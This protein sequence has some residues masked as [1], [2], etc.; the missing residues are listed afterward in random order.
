M[1]HVDDSLVLQS[2]KLVAVATWI[3]WKI[4]KKNWLALNPFPLLVL[5]RF[6]CRESENK[7]RIHKVWYLF[8]P[9]DNNLI[10]WDPALLS[11]QEP[12]MLV[13]GDAY[14]GTRE[15]FLRKLKHGK[16]FHENCQKFKNYKENC[17]AGKILEALD[18][19]FATHPVIVDDKRPEEFS[20]LLKDV[21]E[22][23]YEEYARNVESAE[24]MGSCSE[25]MEFFLPQHMYAVDGKYVKTKPVVNCMNCK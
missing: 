22:S 14:N 6:Y 23:L 21:N 4:I 10:E 16:A 8:K 24:K 12:V 9:Q 11:D 17:D 18:G 25:N 13:K 2:N 7:M 5:S 19:F 3:S 15:D 20:R 1:E